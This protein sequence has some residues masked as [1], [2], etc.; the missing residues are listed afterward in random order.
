M[1]IMFHL[2][3][4]HTQLG[5]APYFWRWGTCSCWC[6]RPRRCWP[7]TGSS[8]CPPPARVWW[9]VSLSQATAHGILSSARWAG[10]EEL[11]HL[12][13]QCPKKAR[14]I[15]HMISYN[16]FFGPNQL[17]SITVAM[18]R[19]SRQ[20]NWSGRQYTVK[21]IDLQ[22][23]WILERKQENVPLFYIWTNIVLKT[24]HKRNALAF[25]LE[26]LELKS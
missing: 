9:A 14:K 10:T 20:S 6:Q 2:M 15:P 13:T 19:S 25:S 5:E 8:H 1:Y 16:K 11:P 21:W 4:K 22:N 23:P 24:W 12:G 17:H 26:D 3:Y 7:C 18:F